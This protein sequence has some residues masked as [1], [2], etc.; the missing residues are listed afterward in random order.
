VPYQWTETP[1]GPVVLTLSAHNSLPP[2][3]FVL[4][5]GLTA[6]LITLPM[7]AVLGTVLLWGLLPFLAGTVGAL[8]FALRRNQADRQV[9]ETLER[10]ADE[11]TLTHQPARGEAVSWT[12]NLYWVRAELHKTGG[13][14]EN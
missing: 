1:K 13:P 9:H 6:A 7:L 12:C 2:H 10:Q 3:G 14:V 4:M 5:I 11:L 8:W